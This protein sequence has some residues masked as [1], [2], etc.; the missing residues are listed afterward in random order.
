M[1][2]DATDSGSLKLRWWDFEQ[3]PGDM[4]VVPAGGW[5][6]MTVAFENSISISMNFIDEHGANASHSASLFPRLDLELRKFNLVLY[7]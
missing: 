3:G 4:V 5:W 7:T 2:R 6:H 1:L